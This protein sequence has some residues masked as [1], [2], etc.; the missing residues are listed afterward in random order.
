MISTA[1]LKLMMLKY[2]SIV[3]KDKYKTEIACIN[4]DMQYFYDF[5]MSQDKKSI[6][7]V[8]YNG[9]FYE[10]GDFY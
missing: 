3:Y 2:G 7:Y 8:L 4:D 9:D 1:I 5:E 10:K 6:A